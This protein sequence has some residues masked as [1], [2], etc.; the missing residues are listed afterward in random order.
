MADKK[1][2]APT[3]PVP[4]ADADD[5]EPAT[6]VEEPDPDTAAG[7]HRPTPA[8][9]RYHNPGNEPVRPEV[10]RR[11]ASPFS[12]RVRATQDGYYGEA[13][14]RNGDVFTITDQA[15]FSHKWMEAVDGTT[16]EK[17]TTGQQV[18]NQQHDELNRQRL[19]GAR[20]T[21]A[22]HVLDDADDR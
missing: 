3:D 8:T 17:V 13:R 6:P 21:G 22:S 14:R 1:K 2:P 10:E 16:P 5:L 9:P 18:L 7:P 11:T 20:P 4:L 19:G 12:Q 15:H